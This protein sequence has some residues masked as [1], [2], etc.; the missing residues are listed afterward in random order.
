MLYLSINFA[1]KTR[2]W[3]GSIGLLNFYFLGLEFRLYYCCLSPLG[4]LEV[5]VI[6]PVGCRQCSYMRSNNILISWKLDVEVGFILTT[7]IYSWYKYYRLKALCL[8]DKMLKIVH[9]S[10]IFF[11][12]KK[13]EQRKKKNRDQTSSVFKIHSFGYIRWLSELMHLLPGLMT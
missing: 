3:A 8:D 13:I 6:V 1:N 7:W 11:L 9:F 4:T 2:L 5:M 10:T 12:V